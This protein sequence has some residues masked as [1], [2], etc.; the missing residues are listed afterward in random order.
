MSSRE[1]VC[2]GLSLMRIF[3]PMAMAMKTWKRAMGVDTGISTVAALPPRFLG[4]GYTDSQNRLNSPGDTAYS[5]AWSAARSRCAM[6]S[7]V[8]VSASKRLGNGVVVSARLRSVK[9]ERDDDPGGGLSVCAAKRPRRG[10]CG[11]GASGSTSV[12]SS[13]PPCDSL[14]IDVEEMEVARE[15]EPLGGASGLSLVGRWAM[16]AHSGA[17]GGPGEGV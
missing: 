15:R 4:S 10:R 8:S 11:A 12:S 7:A 17:G 3:M 9:L 13:V 5:F 2:S 1:F 6:N 14:S 16:K